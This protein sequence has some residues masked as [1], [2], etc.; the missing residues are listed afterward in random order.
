MSS[1]LIFLIIF[2]LKNKVFSATIQDSMVLIL[3][4]ITTSG[5]SDWRQMINECDSLGITEVALFLTC[6]SAF[7]R[8]EAYEALKQ[9]S[10]KSIPFVHLRSDMSPEEVKYL[11]DNYGTEMFN[12]HSQKQFPLKH[13][14]SQ[15]RPLIYLEN[16]DYPIADEIGEWAGLCLDV[17]HQENKRL[18]NLPLYDEVARILET[19]PVGCW[20]LNAIKP[21]AVFKGEEIGLGHDLH[22]FE[23]LSEFDY[24][25]SYKD[26]LPRFIA[27]E[28]ENSLAEQLKAKDYVA[29]LL[30]IR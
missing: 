30:G 11:M 10:I 23:N 16:A 2:R 17:S 14:L 18:M 22:S 8:Q 25:V 12:I 20:H 3:P 5:N 26:Y 28:L 9:S 27:L 15:F 4:S 24:C 1:R 19:H 7:K 6:L 21:Q 13:D 29:K